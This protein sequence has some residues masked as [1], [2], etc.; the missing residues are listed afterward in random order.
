MVLR[1]SL[2]CPR[3]FH[4]ATLLPNG[5]V[6]VI[7]GSGQSGCCVAAVETYDPTANA[8]S[9]ATILGALELE[10]HIAALLPDGTVLVVGGYGYPGPPNVT[11]ATGIY[12]PVAKTWSATGSIFSIGASAAATLLSNGAVLVVGGDTI[13]ST[14]DGPSLT[15][16]GNWTALAPTA[17]AEVYWP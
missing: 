12:N 10:D 4:T 8:W 7:G 1:G 2:T 14:C 15:C 5:K 9:V 16:P 3:A 17:S 13:I 11:F 6:I